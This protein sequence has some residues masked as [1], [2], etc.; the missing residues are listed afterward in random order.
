[1]HDMKFCCGSYVYHVLGVCLFFFKQKTAYDMRIS[2]WSAD[3]CSSDLPINGPFGWHVLKVTGIEPGKTRPFEEVRDKLHKELAREEA[4]DALYKL[5]NRL[6][7]TLGGGATL[8]EAADQLNLA[9]YRLEPIDRQGNNQSGLRMPDLPGQPFLQTAFE[10]EPNRESALT[11]TQQ[12]GYFIL[13]VDEV[14]PSALKPLDKVREEA[15]KLWQEE[16]RKEAARK[17][18]E[19]IVKR[20]NEGADLAKIATEPGV[21]TSTT[22]RPEKRREGKEWVSTCSSRGSPY[23]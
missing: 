17:K 21:K 2:D 19:S 5:S 1:M 20:L 14:I 4:V 8:K 9:L 13:R 12:G 10:S 3:V 23:H 16:Q 7:D 18:A 11:E 15:V 22:E 6:E